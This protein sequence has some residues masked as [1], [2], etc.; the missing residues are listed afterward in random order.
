MFLIFQSQVIPIQL[1]SSKIGIIPIKNVMY[2]LAILSTYQYNI[3]SFV[4][5]INN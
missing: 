2:L 3:L 4:T 1:Q 5:K